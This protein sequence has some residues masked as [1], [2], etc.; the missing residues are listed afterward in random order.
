M[1]TIIDTTDFIIFSNS[2]ANYQINKQTGR[3]H[4][5]KIDP[6]QEELIPEAFK[7]P[8][9]LYHTYSDPAH[10]I[11]SKRIHYGQGDWFEIVV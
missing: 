9:T 5:L 3:S 6:L 10:P 7:N 11:A 1:P 8:F 4:S 2:F